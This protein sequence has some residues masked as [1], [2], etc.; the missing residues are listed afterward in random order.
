MR[1]DVGLIRIIYPDDLDHPAR[2]QNIHDWDFETMFPILAH[3]EVMKNPVFGIFPIAQYTQN[4]IAE[5]LGVSKNSYLLVIVVFLECQDC[6][7]LIL[8]HFE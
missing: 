5:V 4:W 3:T 1:F 2:V 6:R 8:V 7:T